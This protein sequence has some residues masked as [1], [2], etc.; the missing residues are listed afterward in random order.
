MDLQQVLMTTFILLEA[1]WSVTRGRE[2]IEV[3]KPTHVIVHRN[4]AQ[5]YY[6]LYTSQQALYRLEHMASDLS[7]QEALDLHETDTTPLVDIHSDAERAPDRC[8]VHDEGR[9]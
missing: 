1:E 9:L 3:L 2:L 8:I 5:E 6:S 4:G 7:I